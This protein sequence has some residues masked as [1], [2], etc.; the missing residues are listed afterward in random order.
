M[1]DLM[2]F[3]EALFYLEF[4]KQ[5][6]CV[7]FSLT[8]FGTLKHDCVIKTSEMLSFLPLIKS[9]VTIELSFLLLI[10][11]A[12]ISLKTIN[13]LRFFLGLYSSIFCRHLAY[14]LNIK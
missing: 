8:S 13:F 6:K 3:L 11:S 4:S 9:S 14:H 7:E 1:N 2:L 10:K 12:I 5:K